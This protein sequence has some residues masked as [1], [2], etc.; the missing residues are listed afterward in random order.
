[1]VLGI[2]AGFFVSMF[3]ILEKRLKYIITIFLS[4]L[5]VHEENIKRY[6]SKHK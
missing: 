6:K 4:Y 1:M 3:T 2:I 5:E